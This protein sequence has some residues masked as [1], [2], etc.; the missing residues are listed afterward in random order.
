MQD[1]G[2]RGGVVSR[3]AYDRRGKIMR[4]AHRWTTACWMTLAVASGTA[5]PADAQAI[6][7]TIDT[8]R[9]SAAV[10]PYEYGMFIE[11]IGGLVNRTLWAEMLD[12]RKF[13]YPVRVE[14]K[15]EKVPDTVEGRP[16]PA[17]RKWRP[18]GGEDAVMMDSSDPFVGRHSPV[19]AL[20]GDAP[21]GFGQGG[22]AT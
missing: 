20:S 17:F 7:A 12:D 1:E 6:R 22:M 9:T 11:P 14:G 2:T 8:S 5:A 21:R 3:R 19:V 13:H 10:T 18:I 15:D 4:H 16:A